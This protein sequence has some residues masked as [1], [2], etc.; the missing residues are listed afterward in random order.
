M[1]RAQRGRV[2][3]MRRRARV[4]RAG[5]T[6][7]LAVRRGDQEAFAP[8]YDATSRIVFGI[9]LHVA[10][11]PGPSR[12]SHPGGLRGRL[13]VRPPRSTRSKAQRR[14]GSTPSPTARRSTGSGRR[15]AAPSATSATSSETTDRGASPTCPTSWW[16]DDEG[17]RVR[18]ALAQL[19]EAQRTA[20]ELAYFEASHTRGGRASRA[21]RSAPPRP[22]SETP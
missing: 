16:R 14:P 6:C 11:R 19:P 21:S 18:A 7:W 17:R 8:F 22:G 3:A 20:V 12:G 9:V 10:A 13:E 15:S 1:R 2:V 5:T 4:D